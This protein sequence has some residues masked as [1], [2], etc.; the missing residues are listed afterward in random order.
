[1]PSVS[2]TVWRSPNRSG[3]VKSGSMDSCMPTP[4]DTTTA[5]APSRAASRV[6]W[7]VT[8][9][10]VSVASAT[11]SPSRPTTSRRCGSVSTIATS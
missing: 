2:A 4:T 1:M 5:S 11:T 9:T 8:V 7:V 10:G 3:M 6:A